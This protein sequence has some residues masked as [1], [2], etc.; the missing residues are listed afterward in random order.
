MCVCV[1]VCVCAFYIYMC[2]TL[3]HFWA[4]RPQRRFQYFV[5]IPR[6]V[7]NKVLDYTLEVHERT[8][9]FTHTQS[10]TC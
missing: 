9:R 3:S 8:P 2:K 5:G 6:I 7:R 1:C 10:G 4:C